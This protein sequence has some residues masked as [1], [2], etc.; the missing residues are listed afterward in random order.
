MK[1]TKHF[2]NYYLHRIDKNR[3]LQF[4][5]PVTFKPKCSELRV[6]YIFQIVK[7]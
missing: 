6:F 2:Q 5:M 4:V 3:E 1:R 7:K